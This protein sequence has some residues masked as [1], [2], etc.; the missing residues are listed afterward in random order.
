MP[1][2]WKTS[3]AV[4]AN[5]PGGIKATVEGIYSYNFNEVYANSLGY[6]K[7]GTVKLPGEPEARELWTSEGIKNSAGGTMGGYYI[8]NIK[9]VNVVFTPSREMK[10]CLA[11][12][13][14]KRI[15]IEEKDH[16]AIINYLLKNEG[17]EEELEEHRALC[18]PSD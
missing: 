8:H 14:F 1:T 16:D 11:D 6:A 18:H 5:L 12:A 9:G 13:V 4:D 3:V 15:S 10:E 7:T 2:S 17:Y